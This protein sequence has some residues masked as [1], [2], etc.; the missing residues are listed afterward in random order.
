MVTSTILLSHLLAS[1]WEGNHTSIHI[2]PS[3]GI[4]FRPSTTILHDGISITRYDDRGSKWQPTL[5]FRACSCDSRM[6]WSSRGGD[7]FCVRSTASFT[8]AIRCHISNDRSNSAET[9][10]IN[11]A[12]G[13][14]HTICVSIK[15]SLKQLNHGSCCKNLPTVGSYQRT[16]TFCS[17][18]V[19]ASL[20]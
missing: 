4:F 3:S 18:P 13:V 14:I 2:A 20:R 5:V 10:R 12:D 6:S 15:G 7:A 9:V 11:A 8:V 16:P 19:S 1:S 17:P